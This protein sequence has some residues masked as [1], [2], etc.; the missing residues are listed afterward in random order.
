MQASNDIIAILPWISK[1]LQQVGLGAQEYEDALL[2]ESIFRMYTLMQRLDDIMVVKKGDHIQD[3]ENKEV[4]STIIFQRLLNQL[5]DSTRVPFHGEPAIGIQL[6]G[7]LETRN[8]DFEHILLLSCNE[9]NLPKGI[10]DASFIPH[11]IRKGYE[12]TTIEKKIP[13]YA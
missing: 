4:V 9:G 2:H 12:L 7:V 11:V 13:I 6:M 1:V 10:N 5:I 3:V 8:L